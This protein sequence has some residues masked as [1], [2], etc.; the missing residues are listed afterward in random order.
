M[1]GVLEGVRVLE[2]GQV[3]AGPFAGAI[4]ADLG[5]EV[6]KIE[7]V[8][9]GD[10][11]RRMGPDFRHGDALNFH[12]FNRGKQSVALDL[13]SAEGRA[14]FERLAGEADIFI[15]NLRPGVPAKLG[16][17]G[18]ALCAR[19]PRLIYGEI[20]AFGHLGPMA[21]QPGYEPLVQAFS[22][23]SST[24]GGPDDPPMRSAAS[25]CD[26]GSGM[27]VV[28]GALALLH[29]RAQTGRGGILST[30][31]LETALVWNGQKADAYVNEGRLPVRDRSGHPGFV[32]YEAFDTQDAPLLICCGNDRLFAKLAAALGR[33]DWLA[34]ERLATNRARLAH[35]A[36]LL[37]QL[38][39]LLRTRPR[40]E[41]RARLEAAGVPCA[42]I[43]S[44]PEALAHPQVQ[45]LG[46]L[47]AVP[48]QDFALTALPL[49]ID[50]QRPL[51]RAAAPGLGQHNAAH[52][53]PA[54]LSDPASKKETS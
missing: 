46:I 16:I 11:A 34:D 25:L 1:A 44:V 15:H 40:A 47:A 26:Q 33:P 4:L 3:L 32:P 13:K 31:L 54:L 35:K 51:P 41:W 52:G 22:G 37:E 19:H 38:A 42:P 27:W 53:V 8:E 9:G 2:L 39:P 43:H 23:L 48:G 29:R 49:T 7:R 36:A 17:D 24:N 45:A 12:I 21:R 28:I 10:D 30:S 14:A 6:V 20:S 18:P 50:G 5:A